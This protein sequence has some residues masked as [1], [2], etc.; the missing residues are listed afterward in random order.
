MEFTELWKVLQGGSDVAVLGMLYLL[1]KIDRRLLW[2]ENE[3]DHHK[4]RL[5]YL[6]NNFAGKPTNE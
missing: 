4:L 1:W 5:D 2:L 3:L 6:H